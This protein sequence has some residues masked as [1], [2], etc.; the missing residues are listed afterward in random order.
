M[1]QQ[2]SNALVHGDNTPVILVGAG[3]QELSITSVELVDII[4]Q[5]RKEEGNET[6]KRH[7]DLMASIKNEREVL[8]KAGL[9]GE[10]NFS[11]TSYRDSQGKERP[12]YSLTKAG[13]LQM[14]NKESAVVRYKTVCYIEKLEKENRNIGL[15]RELEII[16]VT[17]KKL[18]L[19]KNERIMCAISVLDKYDSPASEHFKKLIQNR[20]RC[21]VGNDEQSAYSYI[22][23]ISPVGNV[24][25]D[26][27]QLYVEDCIDQKIKPI[28]K[29]R[30]SKI[31]MSMGYV[32]TPKYIAELKAT[33][34]VWELKE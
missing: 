9:L 7:G 14:L 20:T 24:C 32:N 18:Q 19:P 26:Y 1:N 12:C 4:N 28:S 23:M 30:L 13:V 25:S 21:E 33:K 2:M 3:G 22:K 11:L 10:R 29:A 31:L 17:S 27:Y 8:E 15:E 34:R 6:E 16:S 5:F